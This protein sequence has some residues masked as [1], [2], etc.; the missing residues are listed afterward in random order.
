MQKQYEQHSRAD[1]MEDCGAGRARKRALR[2]DSQEGL[3]TARMQNGSQKH[4]GRPGLSPALG[5]GW[6]PRADTA[7]TWGSLGASQELGIARWVGV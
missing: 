3:G 6:G 4:A 1:R 7:V 2:R 5:T